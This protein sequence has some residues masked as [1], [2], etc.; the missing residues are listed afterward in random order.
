ML[1]WNWRWAWWVTAAMFI[2]NNTFIQGLHVLTFAK[3]L[4][5]MTNGSQC[6]IVFSVVGAIICWL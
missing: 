4:N 1:F 5:T 3:Y 6:T 2:L